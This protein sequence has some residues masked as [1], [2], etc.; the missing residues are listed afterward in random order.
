V[1]RHTVHSF[2]IPSEL[3]ASTEN[4]LAECSCEAVP[5]YFVNHATTCVKKAAD[6]AREGEYKYSVR[7]TVRRER[8]RTYSR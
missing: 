1:F 7:L 5:L 4:A 3:G 2:P 6:S 8:E